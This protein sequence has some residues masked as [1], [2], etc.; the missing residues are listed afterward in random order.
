MEQ[1]IKKENKILCQQTEVAFI[2]LA[3]F[4]AF[5]RCEEIL[6]SISYPIFATFSY[7][8]SFLPFLASSYLPE[9]SSYQSAKAC[10]IV[11]DNESDVAD[12]STTSPLKNPSFQQSSMPQPPVAS[13][14]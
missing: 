7:F 14:T 13:G 1:T 5:E 9:S 3:A 12:S 11:V 10:A 8:F 6:A 4:C 2:L